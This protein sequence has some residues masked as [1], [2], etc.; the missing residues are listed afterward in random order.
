MGANNQE[1]N[2]FQKKMRNGAD[3]FTSTVQ[4]T[5]SSRKL[6]FF[7]LRI[8]LSHQMLFLLCNFITPR[9]A[10]RIDT[11]QHMT[12]ALGMIDLWTMA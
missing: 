8:G 9:G 11:R 10:R 12:L 3:F 6:E 5:C 2:R 7:V 1:V 4:V